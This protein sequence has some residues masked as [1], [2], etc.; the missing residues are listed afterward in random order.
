MSQGSLTRRRTWLLFAMLLSIHIRVGAEE[1]LPTFEGLNRVIDFGDW[2]KA[3]TLCNEIFQ[4]NP[5]NADA[6]VARAR[7][8]SL[9]GKTSEAI[10]DCDRVLSSSPGYPIALNTRGI[11]LCTTGNPK[12]GRNDLKMY[13]ELT[14]SAKDTVTRF[15]R[16]LAYESLEDFKTAKNEWQIILK[17]TASA[18]SPEHQYI[19]GLAQS[20]LEMFDYA[21]ETLTKLRQK[22]TVAPQLLSLLAHCHSELLMSE[23]SL[24]EFAEV[25]QQ[26]PDYFV[27]QGAWAR[28]LLKLKRY[29]EAI[30]HYDKALQIEEHYADALYHRGHCFSMLRKYDSAVKDYSKVLLLEP[31]N[32]AAYF[33]RAHAYSSLG[34]EKEAAEDWKRQTLLNPKDLNSWFELCNSLTLLQQWK[35]AYVAIN[36]ALNLSPKWD[37]ALCMRAS[38]EG[39]MGNYDKAVAHYAD[40]IRIH[41]KSSTVY[42]SRGMFFRN[43]KQY[44]KSIADFTKAIKLD[45]K[46]AINYCARGC[47]EV[48]NHNHRE[49]IADCTKSIQL[50]PKRT[51]PYLSRGEAYS[52]LGKYYLA[53]RDLNRV[54]A[55]DDK[56]LIEALTERA[57]VYQKMNKKS[58]ANSDIDRIKQKQLSKQKV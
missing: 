43:E 47:A 16:A 1:Q 56:L 25:A 58:L 32:Y 51:H 48:R 21:T 14:N 57:K 11:I 53:L 50:N 7:L 33:S 30:K 12:A 18:T 42:Y 54:V 28:A 5:E 4:K 40:A 46:D 29:D 2:N 26:E 41:P 3:R 31:D 8:R 9:T 38:L 17:D 45:P 37:I 55:K 15:H 23:L 52:A 39:K 27:N 10:S 22:H 24:K 34:Q 49:A 20:H 44:A 35:D 36:Q 6:L 19:R 13:L